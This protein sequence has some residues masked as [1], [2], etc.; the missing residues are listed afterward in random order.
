MEQF[1]SLKV[2][3]Q[4]SSMFIIKSLQNLQYLAKYS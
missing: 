2:Q 4:S 3:T 1:M